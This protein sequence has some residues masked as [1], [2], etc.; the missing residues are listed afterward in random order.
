MTLQERIDHLLEQQGS[1]EVEDDLLCSPV[2]SYREHA[3]T[4]GCNSTY[5]V[6]LESGTVAFHK[7]LAG[8]YVSNAS[9]YG[10]D[11]D[12]LPLHECAA[13]RLAE[14]I[15]DPVDDL[16]AV[17]VMR[18]IEGEPGS[19]SGRKPGV[20]GTPEFFTAVQDQCKAAAFFDSLVG[21]QDRHL[22]NVRWDKNERRIGLIDH[23]YSFACPDDI[24]NNAEFLAWRWDQAAEVLSEWERGVLESFVESSDLWGLAALLSTPRVDAL[25]QRAERMLSEGTILK[26]GQF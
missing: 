24:S 26:P 10:H 19:L 7:P 16:V 23:G 14:K 20:P 25:R 17:C 6:V 8:V 2:V 22:G 12:E 1:T 4:P 18:N 9:D 11:P 15:G 5:H 21:Q 3:S 13:W